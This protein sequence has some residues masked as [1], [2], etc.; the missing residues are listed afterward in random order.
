[1]ILARIR[2]VAGRIA[3]LSLLLAPL[4]LTGCKG[5]FPAAEAPRPVTGAPVEAGTVVRVAVL[6][7]ANEVRLGCG[8]GMRIAPED[9]G[10]TVFEKV[11]S[12]LV[13]PAKGGFTVNGKFVLAESLLVTPLENADLDVSGKPYPG[14]LRIY[15]SKGFL[16]GVNL[17][18]VERYVRRVVGREMYASWSPEALKA[19]AVASRS[20]VLAHHARRSSYP[21]DVTTRSQQYGPGVHPAVRA[22][23]DATRGEVLTYNGRPAT[24]Y[25]CSCCGGHTVSAENAFGGKDEPEIV[26]VPSTYC[27][28]SRRY[29]WTLKLDTR[30][31]SKKLFGGARQVLALQCLARRP[32][33]RIRAVRVYTS[34]GEVDMPVREFRKKLGSHEVGSAWFQVK[35]APGGFLFEGRGF[36]HGVGLCQYGA[37]AMAERGADYR[38]ILG[39]FYPKLVV[40]KLPDAE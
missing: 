36:G 14:R 38:A 3:A 20:F 27:E 5:M 21:H 29:R 37:K 17:V 28:G 19:Q 24:G 39:H 23:V 10:G 18:P 6:R 25:F 34:E 12:A 1:M 2:H 15:K 4:A 40:S 22:A 30:T 13:R 32:D 7:G 16:F 8:A 35:P 31:L 33:G 11:D 26:G 9:G